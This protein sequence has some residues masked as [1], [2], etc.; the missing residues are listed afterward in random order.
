MNQWTDRWC[1][2]GAMHQRWW[3]K[4]RLG[5]RALKFNWT[6]AY[7]PRMSEGGGIRCGTGT[8]IQK[9]LPSE[10]FKF[11][12]EADTDLCRKRRSAASGGS[13]R[14]LM[15]SGNWRDNGR[16]H[17][18]QS[19]PWTGSSTA[20]ELVGQWIWLPR[21]MSLRFSASV[22]MRWKQ[23]NPVQVILFFSSAAKF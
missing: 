5:Q 2:L 1:F 8:D 4:W 22:Q 16:N 6:F 10:L 14:R 13:R 7:W 20:F 19:T 18:Q 9:S 21:L 11:W 23:G 3:K 17:L 12:D 15:K